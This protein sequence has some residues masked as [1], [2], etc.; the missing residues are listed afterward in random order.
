ME[1]GNVVRGSGAAVWRST[2]RAVGTAAGAVD[3]V[4]R[5]MVGA[6]RGFIRAGRKA[7]GFVRASPVAALTIA[8][9]AGALAA[10]LVVRR[11]EG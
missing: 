5:Q 1:R 3:A 10:L 11:K 2:S 8:A 9:V 7:P 4:A 6:A